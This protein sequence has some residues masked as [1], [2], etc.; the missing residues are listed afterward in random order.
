MT[1]FPDLRCNGVLCRYGE[2]AIK[3][4]NRGAFE[5]RLQEGLR[6]ALRRLGRIRI[7]SER[8]RLFL[9]PFDAGECFSPDDIEEMRR[10]LPFVN[11]LSSASP[12]ILVEPDLRA[13]ERVV[14]ETFP[15]VY[16][17]LVESVPPGQH[18]TYAMEVRRADKRFPMKSAEVEIHFA[19]RLL[20]RFP[21]LQ[22]DLKRAQLQ[23]EVE[24]RPER[25]FVSYER[26]AGPGGLPSGSGGR[27]LAL[28]SGGID[29]PVAC[30]Q[31]MRRGCLVDFVTFHSSPYT[32][33]ESI[34][35]VARLAS[36]LNRFQP[37]GRLIAVNL[38][39]AQKAVRDACRERYRTVLYRR[40]MVRLASVIAGRLNAGALVTGDNIGQ[41][42]SQTL[43]NLG[44]INQASDML[45]LRPLL[46]ADKQDTVTL[47]RRI[48]TL[49]ESEKDV[50][51]SCTVFAPANPATAARRHRVEAQEARLDLEGL[52][53]RCLAETV[54]VDLET[55][56]Q[57]PLDGWGEPT[58]PV[59]ESRAEG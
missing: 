56:E 39:T 9:C 23:V 43:E 4:R 6:R 19:E 37:P 53:R 20:D 57:R 36:L 30:Y 54:E 52:L 34:I 31:M 42:A 16:E 12:G 15:S 28:L 58:A 50:P 1:Y 49:A 45:V 25:A 10:V 38:L 59:G 32:P 21:R 18:L 13:I 22:V 46:T 51:D 29:S 33:P 2:I 41:V 47:A 24:I 5:N 3:G 44:V 40:L 26:I 8:G 55:F 11:G 7:L 14:D 27:V 17:A 35:K 48:G